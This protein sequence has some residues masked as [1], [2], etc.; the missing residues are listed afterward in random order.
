MYPRWGIEHFP[1]RKIGQPGTEEAGGNCLAVRNIVRR[2]YGGNTR[3]L[4]PSTGRWTGQVG[5]VPWRREQSSLLTLGIM[6]GQLVQARA[7]VLV[8]VS[9]V[10]WAGKAGT[11]KINCAQK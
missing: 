11:V 2:L 9:R 1:I 4:F 3:A 6:Y 5:S 8:K 7:G 10:R